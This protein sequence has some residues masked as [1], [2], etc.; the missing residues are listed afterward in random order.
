MVV[1]EPEHCGPNWILLLMSSVHKGCRYLGY[2]SDNQFKSA[3][4][5]KSGVCLEGIERN[6]ARTIPNTYTK[7][8]SGPSCSPKQIHVFILGGSDDLAISKHIFDSQEVVN[9][10]TMRRSEI[11]VS[12][13]EGQ[14]A[15]SSIC[16]KSA[17]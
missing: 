5:I 12:S 9:Y 7:A 13:A 3:V 11:A 4:S 1:L 17:P 6:E 10:E 8:S 14:S 15:D 16:L 2:I